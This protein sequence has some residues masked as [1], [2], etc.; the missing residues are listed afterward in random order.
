MSTLYLV[1]MKKICCAPS[2]ID[3]K[4]N[5]RP[6]VMVP[7]FWPFHRMLHSPQQRGARCQRKRVCVWRPILWKSN[8]SGPLH[9]YLTPDIVGARTIRRWSSCRL[10]FCSANMYVF[11]RPGVLYE[12]DWAIC[13]SDVWRIPGRSYERYVILVRLTNTWYYVREPYAKKNEIYT[14][15]AVHLYP[16]TEGLH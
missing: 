14:G 9:H 13:T 15:I 12:N 8:K 16:V 1:Y 10:F 4:V 11:I 3:K 2:V 6:N 5:N 7:T